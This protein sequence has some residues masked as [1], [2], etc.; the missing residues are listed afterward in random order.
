MMMN[1]NRF[2]YLLII[3]SF[4]LSCKTHYV[5]TGNEYYGYQIYKGLHSSETA[6]KLIIPYRD[7]LTNKMSVVIG[8]SDTILLKEQPEGT[9]GNFCADAYREIAASY[10]AKKVDVC[11]MNNGGLRVPSLPKGE[12]TVGHIFELM[13][14]DNQLV[15]MDISGKDMLDIC[16]RIAQRGGWPVSGLRMKI[17]NHKAND[18]LIAGKPI[19][20]DETYTIATNDYLANGGDELDILKK[21]PQQT[22]N[23]LLRNALIEYIR[24][25]S[26]MNKHITAHKDQRIINEP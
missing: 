22:F 16:N 15:V 23:L 26:A 7:S 17:T 3:L 25:M 6:E 18:I 14:F 12:I 19:N 11:F 1:K 8:I 2:G 4:L 5:L 21:Y 13:P 24:T 10:V 20:P 9:L